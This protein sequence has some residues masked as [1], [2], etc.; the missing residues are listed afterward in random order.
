IEERQY[1]DQYQA[2]Y[3]QMLKNTSTEY[4]PWYVVP[5]DRKWFSRYLA[6]EILL[7]H[8]EGLDFD[9]PEVSEEDLKMLEESR[10]ILLNEPGAPPYIPEHIRDRKNKSGDDSDAEGNLSAGGIEES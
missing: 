3:E 5:A 7:Q 9:Y 8:M 2:A 4:A 10:D 1:W 6:S